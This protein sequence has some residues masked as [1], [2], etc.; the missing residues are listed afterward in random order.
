MSQAFR[1]VNVDKKE[2]FIAPC[3]SG[4]IEIVSNPVGTGMLTYLMLE[5][6]Q[7]GSKFSSRADPEDPQVQEA[8]EEMIETEAERED[9]RFEKYL[10]ERPGFI[11]S[12][13]ERQFEATPEMK[14]DEF[15]AFCRQ[16]SRSMYRKANLQWN[17]RKMATSAVSK[18]Q[19]DEANEY[20]GRWA[21]DQVSLLGDYSEGTTYHQTKPDWLYETDDGELFVNYATTQAPITPSSIHDEDLHHSIEDRDVEPGDLAYVRHPI[22]DEKVYAH[23]KDTIDSKWTEITAGLR[24]EFENFVGDEWLEN[25]SERGILAPDA[26]LG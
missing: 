23:Y 2:Y 4:A 17:R 13:F 19:I 26:V 6:P 3:P 15:E 1:F 14:P 8:I 9:E 10:E 24:E 12:K 7:D 16:E 20:A 5:G 11:V 21:G 18:L 25:N 22:K